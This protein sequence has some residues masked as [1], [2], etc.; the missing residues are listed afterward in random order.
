MGLTAGLGSFWPK[1][2]LMLRVAQQGKGK[3]RVVHAAAST[4]C[5]QAILRMARVMYPQ[6]VRERDEK[7]NLPLHLAA[8]RADICWSCGNGGVINMKSQ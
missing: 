3:F 8:A 4:P 7:G 5:P 1:V 6:Q 2:E